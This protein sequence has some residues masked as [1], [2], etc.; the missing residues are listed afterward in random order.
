M[1]GHNNQSS[2]NE[3]HVSIYASNVIYTS[4][5]YASDSDK[6]IKNNINI[7]NIDQDYELFNKI[8]VSNYNYIDTEK[9]TKEQ[10]G[11]IAQEIKEHFP[12]AVDQD[13]G[14]IPNIMQNSIISIDEL[15]FF[16]QLKHIDFNLLNKTIKLINISNSSV[17][18]IK[19]INIINNIFY[20]TTNN[21]NINKYNNIFVYGEEVQDLLSLDYNKI[22]CLHFNSTKKLINTVS[23]LQKDILLIKNKLNL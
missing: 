14:F 17:V 2:V 4:S 11:F 21:P 5:Y 1:E 3:H 16:I 22:H 18:L 19:I 20:F 9:S 10:K 8:N 6:R 7:S 23:Q 12:Q 15:G 13:K